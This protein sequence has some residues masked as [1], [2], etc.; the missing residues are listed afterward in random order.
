MLLVNFTLKKIL[1]D[2]NMFEFPIEINKFVL[3]YNGF[4]LITP[5]DQIKPRRK[6]LEG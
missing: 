1:V 5:G 2:R 6:K 3:L 4:R